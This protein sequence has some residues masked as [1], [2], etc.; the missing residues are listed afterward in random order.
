[1]LGDVYIGMVSSGCVLFSQFKVEFRCNTTENVAVL[2]SFGSTEDR[3]IV[4]CKRQ[5]KGMDDQEK[6][7]KDI[8]I[9]RTIA[10]CLKEFHTDWL[11][12]ISKE[13]EN[14]NILNIFT[15]S[16]LVI[17]QR[18]LA[19]VRTGVDPSDAVYPLLFCLKENCSK[20]DLSNAIDLAM[21]TSDLQSEQTSNN[22]SI[23]TLEKTFIEEMMEANFSK[24]LAIK[25]LEVVEP[26][27]ID[28]GKKNQTSKMKT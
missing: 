10:K 23:S 14:K 8:D 2:M 28:K 18:E 24:Y 4:R 22:T 13:R 11:T 5:G 7:K 6:C 9:L 27:Q 26:D 12:Y 20:S 1:M 21:K 15:T 19:T 3:Q 25:A 16:Q 17:L